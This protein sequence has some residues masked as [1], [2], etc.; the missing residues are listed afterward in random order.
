MLSWNIQESC[1]QDFHPKKIND[2]LS[3][4][5]RM[6]ANNM[7][8][9]F[10]ISVMSVCSGFWMC[11]Y[12][13]ICF[14]KVAPTN[15]MSSTV[16]FHVAGCWFHPRDP[17]KSAKHDFEHKNENDTFVVVKLCL[18]STKFPNTTIWIHILFTKTDFKTLSKFDPFWCMF[19]Y[20]PPYH[21]GAFLT[22]SFSTQKKF[23]KVQW[24]QLRSKLH[25]N[26]SKR[27]RW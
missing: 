10:G 2:I 24:I 13:Q 4:Y 5:S 18:Y 16:I 1:P 21:L 25:C 17:E 6:V 8:I 20:K 12:E 19:F 26:S 15:S 14:K 9:V 23:A 27:S 11:L 22:T 3:L 7:L